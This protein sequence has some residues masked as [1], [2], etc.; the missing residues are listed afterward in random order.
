MKAPALE[1]GDIFRLHGPAYLTTFGDSLSHEQKQALRAIAVC[2]TAALGGHVEE[3]DSCGYRK[4][5]YCSCRNRHG[6]KCHGQASARWL[7]QRAEELLPVEYFQV[8][9]TVPQLLAPL[10]LRNQRVVYGMLFRAAAET[11]LQIAAD[12]RHLGARIGFVAVLHTW[13]QNLHQNPHS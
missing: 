13:G 9:C 3:C 11:L 5:S 4:I 12:P 1:L 6:P 8:V 2:R 10:A 7:G